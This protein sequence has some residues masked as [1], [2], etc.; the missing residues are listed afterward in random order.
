M[1]LIKKIYLTV[2]I[3]LASLI[4]VNAQSSANPINQTPSEDDWSLPSYVTKNNNAGLYYA[5]TVPDAYSLL[6]RWKDL[7][8]AENVYNWAAIDNAIALNVPFFIRIWASDTMHCPRWVRAKHPNIPILHNQG[9]INTNTYNDQFGISPSNFFAIWDPG[10]DAEFKKF[11]LAFKSKNYLAN[12]NIKFMYAPGGWR[13]NEWN[14]SEAVD[15]I[16]L[17]APITPTNF[18]TWFKSHLDNYVNA[19]NGYQYKMLFTGYGK[20]ENPALY[21]THLNWFFAANDTTNGDNILTSY[22]V[23]I[24]MG[25]REGG[26]ENFNSSSD[27]YPWGAP[28]ITQNNIN[29]Q[30]VNENHPLHNDSLK[31]LGTENEA[32]CDANALIGGNVCSYYHIKMSTLKAMQLRI[33]WLNVRDS[34]ITYDPSL[35]QYFRLTSNKTA[36]TSPDAWASLRQVHDPLFS[37]IPPTPVLNS[38]RWIHRVT[39]PYRNWEKWLIQREVLP[40][41]KT[42]PVYQLNTNHIFDYYNFKAFEALRTDKINGS[43]YMYFNVDSNFIYGGS[44]DVKIKITYLDNFNGN[45][46]V[47]YDAAGTQVYKQSTQISNVNN[48][49]WKTITI[50]IPD[51]GF[52][53]RQTGGMDFRIYNGGNNDITIR[54]VRVIKTSKPIGITENINDIKNKLNIYPNPSN[55]IL[56]LESELEFK[57]LIIT[58]VLGHIVLKQMDVTNAIDVSKLNSGLYFINCKTKIG[59]LTVSKKFIKN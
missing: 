2:C 31:I 26:Q 34:L 32:F 50:N 47:E 43:N 45:W 5:Y 49:S 36:K 17:K 37:N 52:T 22:A 6:L 59:G 9:G 14:L 48:N 20:V 33:N 51:A 35:F 30:I 29:Y 11:L 1:I 23:S 28:S 44:T 40:N 10:F 55:S 38:P 53:N 42:V 12:P 24:G 58:D 56:N 16:I 41:G 7:N 27:M 18:I 4:T 39:L 19:A 8:P 15:E 21:G 13:Y 54:F 57:E 25:V 46:W 3:Y